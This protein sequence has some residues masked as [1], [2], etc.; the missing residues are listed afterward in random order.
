[1][2]LSKKRALRSVGQELEDTGTP[3]W[4]IAAVA[5]VGAIYVYYDLKDARKR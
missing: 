3:V 1:M 5:A 4:I 2:T